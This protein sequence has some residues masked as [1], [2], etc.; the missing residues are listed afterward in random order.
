MQNNIKSTTDSYYS[1][2]SFQLQVIFITVQHL[3]Q[4][5]VPVTDFTNG[6]NFKHSITNKDM[7]TVQNESEELIR[8]AEVVLRLLEVPEVVMSSR[9]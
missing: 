7:P 5:L 6:I 2:H 9:H 8:A 4:I 1:L 3:F